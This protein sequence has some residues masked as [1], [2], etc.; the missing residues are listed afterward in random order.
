MPRQLHLR[1]TMKN[2]LLVALGSALLLGSVARGAYAPIPEQEQGEAFTITLKAGITGDSNIFGDRASEIESTVVSVSPKAALNLSLTSQTFFS[3]FYQPTLEHFDNRPGDKTLDSHQVMARVAHQFSGATTIDVTNVFT[4]QRNPESLLAGLPVNSDQSFKSN[5]LNLIFDT[6]LNPRS[7][8]TIKGR[9]GVFRYDSAKL[10]ANL[11]RAE[12][13]IGVSASYDMVPELSLNGELRLMAIDYR[14]DGSTK[15]KNSV[16]FL[17]GGD[18]LVAETLTA[19]ARVGV[20]QRDRAGTER[21]S[22]S[23]YFELTGTYDYAEGSLLSGGII[24]AYEEASN[25]AQFTDTKARRFFANLQHAITPL[26]TGS[27]ALHYEPSQLKGRIG[28]AD[29]DESTMRLGLAL[30]YAP[31]PNLSV[32][33]TF[34]RDDVKSDEASR[35]FDRNRFGVSGT[36]TF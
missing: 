32:S 33:A 15:D 36:Y 6:S 29:V 11:D 26:I 23:P 2:H 19:S 5:E 14:T 27:A 8:L 22:R 34:D 4:T 12:N 7:T 16:F 24:M 17:L 28:N 18:Y 1:Y 25:V 30:T 31:L 9:S 35:E 20:E 10:S 13:L 21:S 3:A